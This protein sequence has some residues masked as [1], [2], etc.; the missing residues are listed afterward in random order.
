M[1]ND[2]FNEDCKS[3]MRRMEND[4]LDLIL[5]SPP[6]YNA[7]EYSQYKDVKSYISEMRKIFELAHL[8]LKKSKICIVNISAVIVPRE[9]RSKQSYRI[10]LPYY[11]VPM[12]EDIGF[13]FLEDIIWIKPEGS[14]PN[15]NGKFFTHRKPVAYKP[16][17]VT[18]YV[19]V[20]KKKADFLIDKIIKND[21]LVE[22]GYERTNVWYIN[23]ETRGLHPAPFPE[24]LAENCI[25][26]YSYLNDVVYDP[27]AGS[28]TTGF[29]AKKLKR[30]FILSEQN[31]EYCKIINHR[32][33]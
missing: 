7:K 12:M 29:V 25:K 8:K 17:I 31:K 14:V 19:L 15:R 10:P 3:T 27:F 11:F 1:I 26:Y 24:K 28:G 2:I 21:S 30:N 6:Y 18:E 32:M 4:S 20:F 33:I 5:T 13:E 9:K 16:N 23:P 22:D